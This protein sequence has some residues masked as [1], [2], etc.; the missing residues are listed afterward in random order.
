MKHKTVIIALCAA[1]LVAGCNNS[2]SIPENYSDA[3]FME[4]LNDTTFLHKER[5]LQDTGELAFYA[6]FEQPLLWPE[7][8][9]TTLRQMADFY[10]L[11]SAFNGM[12]TDEH[13]YQRYNGEIE[14]DL[15]KE[16]L[17]DWAK[18][19][20]PGIA[21]TFTMRRLGEAMKFI[22]SKSGDEKKKDVT[23]CSE[24]LSTW[25]PDVDSTNVADK[26]IPV[27]T[28][29]TYLPKKL[30]E[31]Y[32]LYVGEEAKPDQGQLQQLWKYYSEEKDYNTKLSILF[33][34]L[35]DYHY[36]G[37]DTVVSLLKDAEQVMTSGNYSPLLPV[38]WRAYRVDYCNKYSCPS[39]YCEIPNVR[40]NYYRR[41]V[42]YTMLRHI[43]NTPDDDAAKVAFY[44]LA[45]RDNINRFGQYYF[46]NQSTAEYIVLFWNGS[47]L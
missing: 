14:R 36:D 17:A 23:D 40:F 3:L 32:E 16:M 25:L 24:R 20:L 18:M 31:N 2:E 34:L 8:G 33:M 35:Y 46:G 6:S 5:V 28:P 38:L 45:W 41:L 11:Q 43:Q 22:L 13:T 12:Y 19:K 15:E 47:V 1:L 26:I 44:S 39:T 29:K 4:M 10:N 9:D 7:T 27:L 42:A 21:D 37:G 30:K